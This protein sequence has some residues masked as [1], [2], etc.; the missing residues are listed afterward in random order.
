MIS[1]T[2][3]V[4]TRSFSRDLILAS[5]D[6]MEVDI[7]SGGALSFTLDCAGSL[8]IDLAELTTDA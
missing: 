6:L 4:F 8:M 3:A 7:S 2:V 1:R 5:R